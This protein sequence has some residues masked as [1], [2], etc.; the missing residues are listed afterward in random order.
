MGGINS[1]PVSLLDK[2]APFSSS[3]EGTLF[4]FTHSIGGGLYSLACSWSGR[5]RPVESVIVNR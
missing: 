2:A 1:G 4:P 3:S 5:I